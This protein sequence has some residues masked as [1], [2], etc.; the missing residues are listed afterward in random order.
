MTS[1]LQEIGPVTLVDIGQDVVLVPSGQFGYP[2]QLGQVVLYNWSNFRLQI[3]DT[4]TG[5][6]LDLQPMQGN[7]Y[8]PP[9][10]G[11]A[12]VA[13]VAAGTPGPIA[14]V[15]GQCALMGEQIPGSWPYSLSGGGGGGG[16]G[17]AVTI[18]AG[19]GIAVTS[20]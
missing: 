6:R 18:E 3:R 4:Q 20:P 10:N 14:E 1:A 9:S 13:R 16:D 8:D 11:A 7:V 5:A 19:A 12:L 17:G 15:T 2:N